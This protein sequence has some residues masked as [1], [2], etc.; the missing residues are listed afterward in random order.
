MTERDQKLPEERQ[1]YVVRHL[2]PQQHGH[3]GSSHHRRRPSPAASTSSRGSNASSSHRGA[4]FS[5][6]GAHRRSSCK[7]RDA[8][9]YSCGTIG[10]IKKVCRSKGAS[11][12]KKR[13]QTV[14]VL[15]TASTSRDYGNPNGD[16]PFRV[17]CVRIASN[18]SS[19]ASISGA[20]SA[21]SRSNTSKKSS[22]SRITVSSNTSKKA[23]SARTSSS[24]K[25]RF[26]RGDQIIWYSSHDRWWYPGQIIAVQS[27]YYK[28]RQRN[29]CEVLVGKP[30]VRGYE[31]Q[32]LLRDDRAPSATLP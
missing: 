32:L 23:S 9:C 30:D 5:C 14:R 13:V 6:G 25:W 18:T 7:F 1:L 15:D 20:S 17:N 31:D 26:S 29:G 24:S 16:T 12:S 4:C 19:A 2:Q 28:I 27:K 8:E 22:S 11:S 10:H 3:S 21:S